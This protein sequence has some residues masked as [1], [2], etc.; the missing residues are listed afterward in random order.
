MLT[1][2][3]RGTNDFLPQDTE[4]WHWMEDIIKKLCIDYGY[5]EIRMPTF[6]HTELFARGVGETTDIVEKEMYTFLDKG[7]RSVTLR[8]EGTASV[9]RAFLENKVFS[10]AQPTKYYYIGPMY[11]YD[12]PQAGRYRQFHQFGVEAFGSS[13]AALDA[14]VIKLAVDLLNRIGL[15]K[16][17]L[18]VNSVGCPEC[19]KVHKEKLNDYLSNRLDELCTTCQKRY[20]KNPLRIFDCKSS[21]CQEIISD[22]PSITSCL[23]K[24]CREH[25][26]KVCEILNLLK[27]NYIIDE[28]LVR[29]LDYYT[30][31][32]FEII[33]EGIGAQSAICGGGRYDKLVEQCGG[34][35]TPGIGF[36][37]GLERLL[38]TLDLHGINI[39]TSWRKKIF[40]AY[41]DNKAKLEAVRTVNIIRKNNISADMDYMG[42]SLKAQLKYANKIDATHTMILGEEELKK[43]VVTVKDMEQGSQEEILIDNIINYLTLL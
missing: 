3:P 11:R 24:E 27:I 20:E 13:D 23:C 17:A 1:K 26:D 10:K 12:R 39:K 31:T 37:M 33:V 2:R 40:V 8:P 34:P 15:D 43:G 38:M 14:E 29:G 7:E 32:T 25:F 5:G 9:V 22:A 4:K 35:D 21:V 30:R 36:A 42:R 19:R 16:L 18:H 41:V 6:E 28:N